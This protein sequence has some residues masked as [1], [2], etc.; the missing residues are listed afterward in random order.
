MV[1]LALTLL[2]VITNRAMSMKSKECWMLVARSTL[3]PFQHRQKIICL[4]ITLALRKLLSSNSSSI[5]WALS[6]FS[7][8]DSACPDLLAILR[9]SWLSSVG[10]HKF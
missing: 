3:V 6:E 7:Q 10:I 8:A 5:S 2:A 4:P 9:P 1:E